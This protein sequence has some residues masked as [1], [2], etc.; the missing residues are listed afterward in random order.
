[1]KV[2]GII[3][4]VL[5]AG[6]F[7]WHSIRVL[8]GT[9]VDLGFTRHGFLSLIGGVMMFAGIWLY[10]EGRRKPRAKA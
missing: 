7:V 2:A 6:L 3:I 1:M 5:G 9:D 8:M 4:G 10:I